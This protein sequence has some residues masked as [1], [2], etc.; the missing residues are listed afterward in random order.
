[1]KKHDILNGYDNIKKIIDFLL[2]QHDVQFETSEN[3]PSK[4]KDMVEY[5]K[6]NGKFLIFNGGDTANY[7]GHEYTLKFRAL[8]EFM[9]YFYELKFTFKDEKTLSDITAHQFYLVGL[10]MNLSI[11]ECLI[12][13]AIMN[14][15][16]KGQIEYYELNKNYVENQIEF[17]DNY[18]QISA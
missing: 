16:I 12:I 4:Y 8:H 1:M 17:I 10:D 15:E 14:A 2:T 13:K 7:L 9:H 5:Y 11:K 6:K 3:A 18:L